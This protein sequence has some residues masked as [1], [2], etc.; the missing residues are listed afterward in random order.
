LMGFSFSDAAI[1]ANLQ[2]G[3]VYFLNEMWSLYLF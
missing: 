1:A 3:H 2:G